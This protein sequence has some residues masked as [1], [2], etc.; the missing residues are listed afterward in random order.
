M[1]EHHIA[2]LD[3]RQ[4]GDEELL[5]SCETVLA[6]CAAPIHSSHKLLSFFFFSFFFA[7]S[8]PGDAEQHNSLS[9]R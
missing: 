9:E 5:S 6:V 2:L 7:V 8:S 3:L 1:A 4:R